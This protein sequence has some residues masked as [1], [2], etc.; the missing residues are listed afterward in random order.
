MKI[1]AIAGNELREEINT[2][3]IPAEV[4]LVWANSLQ[5]L[6]KETDADIYFDLE[7]V[8]DSQRIEQLSQLLP[9]P[10]F[11][12]SVVHTLYEIGQPFIRINA[13]PGFLKRP[14]TE[15]AVVN[16][17]QEDTIR[18][19]FQMIQWQFKV[20][21]DIP[22]MISAR[23]IAMI[24]NEAYY[25]LQDN[26]ST[27]A[28]IDIAM[29]LGTNYPYGPFEWSSLAGLKNIYELLT[30]LSKTDTRYTASDLLMKEAQDE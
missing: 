26:I 9:K 18:K 30:V 14:V 3:K 22:G 12:N 17:D 1:A 24:I 2:K 7:F 29:K 6:L 19:V 4:E 15:I 16:K 10:V 11:I 21:A 23:V 20:V 28:E 27:K 5:G 13:W 8:K 25:T